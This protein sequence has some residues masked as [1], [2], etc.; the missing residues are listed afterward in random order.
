MAAVI[1]YT[2]QFCPYCIRAKH[3]LT[4]KGVKFQEIKVDKKPNLR[5]EMM[6]KSGQRTVPQIWIGEK[7]IGGCDDLCALDRANKLDPLLAAT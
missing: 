5:A 6:K 4:E 1:I 2:T 3:V 7:H